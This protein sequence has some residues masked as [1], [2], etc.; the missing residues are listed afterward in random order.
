MAR[1]EY[2]YVVEKVTMSGSLLIAAFTV[3]H[4]MCTWLYRRYDRDVTVTRMEDGPFKGNA[5]KCSR[6]ELAPLVQQGYEQML[7]RWERALPQL[8][9][10]DPPPP[11]QG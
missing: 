10:A 7:S 1:S 2:V 9:S 4:E 6:M 5:S 8:R 3:K 11:I